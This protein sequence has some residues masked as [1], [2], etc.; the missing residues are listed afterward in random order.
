MLSIHG[1]DVEASA[2]DIR[3]DLQETRVRAADSNMS[4]N[5]TIKV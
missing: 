5:I 3:G 4:V 1:G 2:P